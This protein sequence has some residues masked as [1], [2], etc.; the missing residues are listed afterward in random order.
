MKALA[1][2]P[3][4]ALTRMFYAQLLLILHR[5]DEALAQRELAM[6][7]DPLGPM[8]QLMNFGTL[9]QAG[10]Y[11]TSLSLGEELAAAD[12]ENLN[13]NIMIEISAYRLK[14]YDKVIRAVKYA[15]PFPMEEETYN[16]IERIYRE[17]GIVAAY[18]EILEHLEKFAESHPICFMDMAFRYLVAN[19]PDKAMDW[20][21]K[22]FE[23]HDPQMTYITT[24]AQYFDRLFGNPRF[25]AICEKMNLPL[26]K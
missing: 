3:N 2:N 14:E 7:L 13:I 10:D 9:V 22:G 1:I 19:Q 21:E 20:I 15:L 26:P 11:E 5:S 18:E 17:S 8:M 25:I 4:D 23:M 6:S 12:P 16:E 24:P